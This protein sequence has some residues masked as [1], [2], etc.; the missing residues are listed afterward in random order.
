VGAK[1]KRLLYNI[2]FTTSRKGIQVIMG[3]NLHPK[4][5]GN[6]AKK[7]GCPSRYVGILRD[8]K[9]ICRAYQVLTGIPD[10]PNQLPYI[11]IWQ[12]MAAH[13]GLTVL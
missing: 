9:T 13:R 5:F 11:D 4:T 12:S 1:E 7:V 10:H 8:Q 6:S 2:C 3:W